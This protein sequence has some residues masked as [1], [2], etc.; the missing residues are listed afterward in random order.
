MFAIEARDESNGRGW[1]REAAGTTD[2]TSLFASRSEAETALPE[3]AAS[4]DCDVS[5]L[6]VVEQ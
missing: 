5:D 4:L 3:L 1:S 6:R 2:D